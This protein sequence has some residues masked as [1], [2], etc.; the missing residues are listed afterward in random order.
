MIEP[1]E[2]YARRREAPEVLADLQQR[3]ITSRRLQTWL[4]GVYRLDCEYSPRT[5]VFQFYSNGRPCSRE[6]AVEMI[7]EARA[8]WTRQYGL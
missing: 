8:A 2:N 3:A 4:S 5:A 1:Y 7:D 6:Q